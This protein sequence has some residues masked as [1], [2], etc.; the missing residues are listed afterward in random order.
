[1][2]LTEEQIIDHATGDVDPKNA[3]HVAAC[4]ECR[5]EVD[6]LREVMEATRDDVPPMPEGLFEEAWA[7]AV[8]LFEPRPK[9]VPWWRRPAFLAIAASLAVTILAAFVVWRVLHPSVAT[10]GPIEQPVAESRS[11]PDRETLFATARTATSPDARGQAI[12]AL[13]HFEVPE[14]TG[15]LAA[16]YAAE[17]DPAVRATIIG[18]L[19]ARGDAELLDTL[20]SRERDPIL[21]QQIRVCLTHIRGKDGEQ[22]THG[23]P[24]K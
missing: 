11:A 24:R 16:L 23:K 7:R 9:P 18:M 2:H 6:E 22:L 19:S 17:R 21:Q 14:V 12:V 4:P 15:E 20:Q 13:S 8:P 1:M 3:A 5:R 10:P